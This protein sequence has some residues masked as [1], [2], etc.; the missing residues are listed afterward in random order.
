MDFC[1]GY[2]ETEIAYYDKGDKTSPVF[3]FIH[4]FSQSSLCWKY[5]FSS[6]LLSKFR[7]IFI[8][9]R[10]HGASGKP[11]YPDAYNNYIPFAHDL[12][13]VIRKLDLKNIIPVC[14]S[15]GG[16]WI[17]DYLREFDQDKLKGI[18]MVGATTQ[19]GTPITEKFFGKGAI[20]NLN[21][22]FN[23][24]TKINIEATRSF[25][26]ACRSG[27]YKQKDFED[28]LSYNMIVT[29][30]IRQWVLSRVSD[31]S[32]IIQ[33]LNIPFLQIHGEE[34]RVVL[35]FAGDFTFNQV[36]HD[37]KKMKLYR[38][39]GHSPFIENPCIFNK[40]LENFASEVF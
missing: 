10:G 11:Q 32:D 9:M 14:W 12:N 39:V 1:Q 22:L 30:K 36:K 27:K 16:N 6:D 31:N 2:S 25:I 7:L 15:M 38:G 21:N 23:P 26:Y 19:Q 34:D 13:A 33:N 17:C 3:L 40:D 29:P 8:D 18:I 5:Q 4:G 24:D 28:I 37:N 20:D 35:P